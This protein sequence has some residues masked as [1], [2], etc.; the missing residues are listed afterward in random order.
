MIQIYINRYITKLAVSIHSLHVPTVDTR[1]LFG[2][3]GGE[4]P[5]SLPSVVSYVCGCFSSLQVG[6]HTGGATTVV[7]TQ[8]VVTQ[9]VVFRDYPVFIVDSEGRQVCLSV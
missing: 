1:Q 2:G 7:I 9:P 8:P 6:Y 3:G 5:A 4:W